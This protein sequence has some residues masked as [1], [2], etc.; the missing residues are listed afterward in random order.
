LFNYPPV[1]IIIIIFKNKYLTLASNSILII[2]ILYLISIIGTNSLAD[3]ITISIT[4]VY[5]S[6]LSLSFLSN[7]SGPAL[8]GNLLATILP[9]NSPI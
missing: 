2:N 6:Q 9:D 1:I 7:T 4:N 5:G 3:Y 8:I